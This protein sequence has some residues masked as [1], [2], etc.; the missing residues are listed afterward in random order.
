MKTLPT[1][2][3]SLSKR[4]LQNTNGNRKHLDRRSVS[5]IAEHEAVTVHLWFIADDAFVTSLFDVAGLRGAAGACPLSL[6]V[7]VIMMHAA[8]R[9]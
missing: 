8:A 3:A 2:A 6:E 7:W 9:L 5:S 1:T 4:H